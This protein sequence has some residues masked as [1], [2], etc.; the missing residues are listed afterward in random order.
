MQHIKSMR[1]VKAG[2]A[3]LTG[4][5]AALTLPLTGARATEL[6]DA[7]FTHGA[8]YTMDSARPTARSVAIRG[9]RI[10]CVG[11]DKDCAHLIGSNPR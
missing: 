6:A 3:F 9:K 4:I 2:L 10:L 11:D 5:S 8:V 1:P 7:I